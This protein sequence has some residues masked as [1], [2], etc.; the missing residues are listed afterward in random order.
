MLFRGF[1]VET[2]AH[3]QAF[4]RAVSTELIR[5]GERSSP[6][7]EIADG[8][9]TSTDHPADQPIVLHNEQSY[10]LNWPMRILF[11][12][13]RAAAENGRTPLADSRKILARLSP[14]MVERFE[15]LGVLYVR[16]YVPGLSLPWTEVFQT[17][18][19]G[20]VERYCA[21]ASVE[22]EWV[23]GERLRTRQRRPAVRR[24]PVSGE[25]TWFNHALFFHVT[26]LPPEV[27]R[28]LRAAVPDAD[29]PYNTYY[30]DGSPIDDAT[31]RELRDAY[32][33]ETVRFDWE[34]GDVLLLD[35]MLVAHGREPFTGPREVRAAMVDPYASLY[36]VPERMPDRAAE[37]AV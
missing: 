26:S 30:G 14:A 18:D 1:R 17:H 9:Y 32:D 4:A 5:Y 31:L 12:C 24:H 16:N 27:S 29:L 19:R 3:F 7:T 33:A 2:A 11:F 8:V 15:R 25:R 28:S 6:R 22:F 36:G 21:S 20:E 35:N 34:N 10:T 23:D 37:A 13:S